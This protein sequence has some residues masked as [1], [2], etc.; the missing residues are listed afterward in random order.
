MSLTSREPSPTNFWTRSDPDIRMKVAL[1]WEA[2][3]LDRQ[4]MVKLFSDSSNLQV[5]NH[6]PYNALQH[7]VD[8]VIKKRDIIVARLP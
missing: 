2:T 6:H 8:R 3:G 7:P 1:A 5:L 4:E